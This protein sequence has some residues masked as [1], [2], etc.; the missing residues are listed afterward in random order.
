MVKMNLLKLEVLCA[1]IH[2][3]RE[4]DKKILFFF[5]TRKY[6]IWIKIKKTARFCRAAF[7]SCRAKFISAQRDT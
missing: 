6:I 7:L 4:Q 1:N 3:N 5:M 2:K